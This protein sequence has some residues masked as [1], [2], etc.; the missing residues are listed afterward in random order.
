MTSA[1]VEAP[2]LVERGGGD[3]CGS[4]SATLGRARWW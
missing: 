2:L 1:V 3:E 4:G